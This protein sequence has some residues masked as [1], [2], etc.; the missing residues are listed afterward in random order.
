MTTTAETAEFSEYAH[1]EKL[2]STQWVA[3]HV[4][5]DDVVVLES[6]ED[7]LLYSTGHVPGALKIDWHTELNDPVTRD[8]VGPEEFARVLGA[9]GIT[10]DT[11]VVFYVDKSNWRAAYAL[12]VFTLYAHL[13]TRLLNG[14]WATW[15]DEVRETP[16]EAH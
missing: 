8:F 9:K 4:G 12:W 13:D 10:C 11:T 2:V 1:P 6:D 15:L 7:T 14:G 5:D 16:P 3:D